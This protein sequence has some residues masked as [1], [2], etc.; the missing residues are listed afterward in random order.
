MEGE[1]GKVSEGL[2]TELFCLLRR[3]AMVVIWAKTP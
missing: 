1:Y 2:K 3:V